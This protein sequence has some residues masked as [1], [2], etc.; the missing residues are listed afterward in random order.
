MKYMRFRVSTK[1]FNDVINITEKISEIVKSSNIE[2]GVCLIFVA[3]S[4]C[5]LTTIEY[6][7]GVINDLKRVLEKIAP[8]T[9]DY[10][11]N[12]KWGDGNGFSHVR[13]ALMKPDLIV[14]I[15]KGELTLGQ[16]QQI[17]LLDFDNKPREREVI[18]KIIG[19]KL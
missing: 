7:E 12:K 17:V 13:A 14:P 8:M 4:T 9:E 18:V 10:E 11:H 15:E 3:H 2:D 6:E 1:G 16:W 19:Q 5:A